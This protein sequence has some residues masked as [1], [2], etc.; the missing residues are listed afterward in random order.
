VA[1]PLLNNGFQ[2]RIIDGAL[3]QDYPAR[4]LSEM[5]DA[6]CLGVSICTGPMIRG[7]VRVSRAVK[8]RYP[9]K[10]V[11][12]GG[13]HPSL[14]PEQTLEFRDVDGVV[15]G[16]GELTF[17]EIAERLAKGED[18]TDVPGLLAKSG[19]RMVRNPPRQ[20]TAIADL[21]SRVPAYDLIDYDR[22]ERYTGV[23]WLM[24][25]SSHGCP[26]RCGYCSNASIYGQRYDALPAE[27]VIDEVGTLVR[28]HRPH[29]V[30]ICDDLFYA[31]RPRSIEIAEGFIRSGL[32]FQWYVV[33]RADSWSALSV[34]Q[35]RLYRRSGLTRV[36][37]GAESGSDAVLRSIGKKADV[38][39]LW[40]AVERCKAADIRT[41]INVIFG[42]PAERKEDVGRTLNLMRDLS[43]YHPESD[44]YCFFFT[45]Y[46]GAPLWDEVVRRGF[47]PPQ[48]F[49]AWADHKP[50][51]S[52]LPWLRG[53]DLRRLKSIRSVV[54]LAFPSKT[55][56]EMLF[57]GRRHWFGRVFGRIARFRFE[58][59]WFSFPLDLWTFYALR[60]TRTALREIFARRQ[61]PLVSG[62]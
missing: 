17:L 11:I 45:P 13:W 32:E 40:D 51:I 18:F 37:F 6:L 19:G 14:L 53:D 43:H 26:Y 30:G 16:Q 34:E 28:R 23:R 35:A 48:R 41:S 57:P 3:E 58:R 24:Y 7:A 5:E 38:R 54:Y 49:E 31:S 4:V 1:A 29:L 20:F 33:D 21:P 2:V 46:P 52:M 22:Y 55:A 27:R 10:P 56:R 50:N 44:F 8:E 39:S 9:G 60:R 36:H 12:F 25:P 62:R 47:R 59:F 15:T 61:N 42:L